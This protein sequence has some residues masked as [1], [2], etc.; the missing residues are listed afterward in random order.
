MFSITFIIIGLTVLISY[1][2][3]SN[4]LFK[5]KSM[6]MPYRVKY[7]KEYYRIMSH[8]FVHGDWGHLCFNMFSLYF[9]GSF[10]ETQ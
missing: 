10:L 8:V 4:D 1:Q 5:E 9:L 7:N 3:F 6:Y 2:G